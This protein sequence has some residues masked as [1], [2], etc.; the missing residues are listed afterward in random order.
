MKNYFKFIFKKQQNKKKWTKYMNWHF[1]GD[2]NQ[3]AN[4]NISND[5]SH[6]G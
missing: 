5:Q 3:I 1:I 4:K 2:K 6:W